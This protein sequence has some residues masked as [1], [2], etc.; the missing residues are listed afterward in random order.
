MPLTIERKKEIIEEFGK[1]KN[2]SGATEVQ[3]AL[4]TQRIRD[5]TDHVNLHKKDNHSRYG[6]VKLVAQRKKLLKYL[7]KTN[8][9]TFVD[10]TTKLKI[11]TCSNH[12]SSYKFYFRTTLKTKQTAAEEAEYVIMTDRNLRYR[13]MNCFQLS[14]LTSSLLIFL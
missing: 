13:K 2:D 6:L 7:N 1:T 9:N 5:L 14:H 8:P 11:R 12:V 3:I 10:L 4:L